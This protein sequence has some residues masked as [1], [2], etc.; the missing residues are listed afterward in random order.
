MIQTTQEPTG[1]SLEEK[2]ILFENLVDH[3][4]P[5]T[6]DGKSDISFLRGKLNSIHPPANLKTKKSDAD[7][8]LVSDEAAKEAEKLLLLNIERFVQRLRMV[9]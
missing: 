4:L 9:S 6:M 1:L 3:G 8:V 5:L 2:I 7:S